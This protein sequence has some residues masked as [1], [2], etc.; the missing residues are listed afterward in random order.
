MIGGD[1]YIYIMEKEIQNNDSGG[2][3]LKISLINVVKCKKEYFR[4][5]NCTKIKKN[6]NNLKKVLTLKWRNDMIMV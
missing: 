3:N 4:L 5:C 1:N 2:I 6:K